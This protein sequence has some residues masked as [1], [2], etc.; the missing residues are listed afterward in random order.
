MLPLMSEGKLA[1]TCSGRMP[2]PQN[3]G[4][5]P[6][7]ILADLLEHLEELWTLFSKYHL[8]HKI[9]ARVRQEG[10]LGGKI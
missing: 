8:Q 10:H 3:S 4:I 2:V 9:M 6:L 5:G 1:I 7:H